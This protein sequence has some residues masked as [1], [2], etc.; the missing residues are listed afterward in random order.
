MVPRHFQGILKAFS[1][2]FQ[3]GFKASHHKAFP[4]DSQGISKV[5]D[6]QA[7]PSERGWFQGD[8][9]VFSRCF[10]G[11]LKA[12]PRNFQG[13]SNGIP[14]DSNEIQWISMKSQGMPL[15]TNEFQ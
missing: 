13:I 8:F 5:P 1:R 3:G 4:S 9:K 12:L 10:Q 11:I 14:M 2:Q 15:N 6:D 7:E